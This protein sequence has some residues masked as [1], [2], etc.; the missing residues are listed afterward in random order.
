MK[1]LIPVAVIAAGLY[2][3]KDQLA[4]FGRSLSV[5][6]GK[7]TFDK[8]KSQ[9]AAF[10]RLY[11]NVNFIVS[12]PSKVQGTVKGAKLNLIVNKKVIASID[13]TSNIIINA[14]STMTFPVSV[15]INPLVLVPT[16]AD[17]LKI[18]GSGTAVNICVVGTMVTNYGNVN[19]NE[20]QTVTL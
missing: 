4:N 2:Y 9:G 18:L 3:F 17:L 14:G 10:L 16:I 15:I 1:I 12:N 7:I 20:C 5:K 8:S 6:L 11:F 19:V 13:N